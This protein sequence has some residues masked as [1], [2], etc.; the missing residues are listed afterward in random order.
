VAVKIGKGFRKLP[1]ELW[2]LGELAARALQGVEVCETEACL[3]EG[4]LAQIVCQAIREAGILET[5]ACP[6]GRALLSLLLAK[7]KPANATPS[8]VAERAPQAKK[9]AF[10]ATRDVVAEKAAQAHE[11]GDACVVAE[12]APQ[13][14]EES[15]EAG[16]VEEKAPC[17][18]ADDDEVA[19]SAGD[20]TFYASEE[21]SDEALSD[22]EASGPNTYEEGGGL[23]TSG[24]Q[25]AQRE[26]EPID[27]GKKP[28]T[29]KQRRRR[30][31]KERKI[32][33]A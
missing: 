25:G 3:V 27:S 28:E 32:M 16:V 29:A 7:G 24:A 2:P 18:N 14:R 9:V 11:E 22:V 13:A 4:L 8:F 5:S 21:C 17:A 15:G 1:E 31:Q 10:E 12:N 33:K 23:A 20:S 6:D 30:R 19:R 26:N